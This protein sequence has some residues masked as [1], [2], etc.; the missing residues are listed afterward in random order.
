MFHLRNKKIKIRPAEIMSSLPKLISLNYHKN[1]ISPFFKVGFTIKPLRKFN[2]NRISE[3]FKRLKVTSNDL[4]FLR[5]LF[6]GFFGKYKHNFG[7]KFRNCL[8][9]CTEEAL[10]D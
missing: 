3:R 6:W 9:V 10:L 5:V 8:L 4:N 2:S 7:N 1:I